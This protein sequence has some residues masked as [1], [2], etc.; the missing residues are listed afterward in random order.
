VVIGN[1]EPQQSYE[2]GLM[3][4][5]HIF[6]MHSSIKWRPTSSKISRWGYS[7]THN[8]LHLSSNWYYFNSRFNQ[9][10]GERCIPPALLK[11]DGIVVAQMGMRGWCMDSGKDKRALFPALLTTAQQER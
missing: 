10:S 6:F 7:M 11:L 9:F 5:R 8:S 1:F 4:H 2:G 3:V